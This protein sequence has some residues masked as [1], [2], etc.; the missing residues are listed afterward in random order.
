MSEAAVET[1]KKRASL[2]APP[3]PEDVKDNI[4]TGK[5]KKKYDGPV[6][7]LNV[8]MP[9]GKHSEIKIAA[10]KEGKSLI[11]YI[12]DTHDHYQQAKRG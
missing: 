9:T 12:I 10:I 3:K 1:T 8:R 5:T 11:D 6:T 2:G 7:Q 4:G